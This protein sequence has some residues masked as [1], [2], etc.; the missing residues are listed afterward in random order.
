MKLKEN[1]GSI[2]LATLQLYIVTMNILLIFIIHLPSI[3]S[4]TLTNYNHM[5]RQPLTVE[6]NDKNNIHHC[7]ILLQRTKQKGENI[8]EKYNKY[9]LLY[10]SL[11]DK[12][13]IDKKQ[14][15]VKCDNKNELGNG[16]PSEDDV[17][18][19]EIAVTASISLP[20]DAEVAFDA[21]SDL[22][23]QPSWSSWLHSV[24]YIDENII[25]KDIYGD[26]INIQKEEREKRM[27]NFIN[28]TSCIDVTK[29]RE[30]KWVMGWKRIRFSWKS[31]VTFMERPRCIQ[32]ESTSGL[33]NKGMITF[34][35]EDNVDNGP[36]RKIVTRMSLTMKFVAP[37]IV[38][39]VMKRSEKISTFMTSQI[40]L[41]T[42]T[43]FR[44]VVLVED[45]GQASDE[46]LR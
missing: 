20:F 31:K 45:L 34:F 15:Q 27:N 2:S 37:K 35:E 4:F 24:S 9:S 23:R 10:S 43:N 44:D 30:T 28:G 14:G 32:W 36:E 21:F 6:Y 13:I 3:V 39:A 19:K 41:P 16:D 8:I 17:S 12:E 22:T 40:L 33:K 7:F 46:I 25:G 18:N 38:A 11:T 1:T 26:Q 5:I 29:L 42:L